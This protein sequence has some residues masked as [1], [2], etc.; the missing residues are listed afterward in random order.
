MPQPSQDSFKEA[1]YLSYVKA[2]F[3]NAQSWGIE[4]DGKVK[5]KYLTAETAF[6]RA[7]EQVETDFWSRV[8]IIPVKK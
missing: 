3:P 6:A 5:G 1:L 4:I 8:N 2:L 7:K